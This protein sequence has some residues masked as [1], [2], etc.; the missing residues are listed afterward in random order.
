MSS[1]STT[2]PSQ[3]VEPVIHVDGSRVE[4]WESCPRKRYWRYEHAGTGITKSGEWLDPLIGTAVHNGIELLV[5]PHGIT[6]VSTL[7]NQAV[8][9]A[10]ETIAAARRAGPVSIY[11]GSF[12]ERN[13]VAELLPDRDF[14]QGSN[15]AEA[16]VRGWAAVRMPAY[17]ATHQVIAI[18]KECNVTFRSGGR[19]IQFMVR[20]DVVERRL[21][22]GALFARN[23]KTTSRVDQK[24]KDKWRH[25]LI[26]FSE[27]MAIESTLGERVEGLII[28]GLVKGSREDY[29]RE[30][31]PDNGP[32]LFNWNSPLVMAWK[33]DGE[34]P[35][36]EDQWFAKYVWRC[37]GPHEMGNRKKCPGGVE[38]R[39]SGVHKA[40][41]S[42]FPG[43][44]AGW[45]EMLRVEEPELLEQQFVEL[46]P[47]TRS[48]YEVERWQRQVLPRE[49]EIREHREML[50]QIE[51]P[52]HF[53]AMLDR[54]FPMST[55][56]GNCLW[57]SKCECYDIC[58]GTDMGDLAA[59]GWRP[60]S[61][62]HPQEGQGE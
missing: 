42:A 13:G 19:V 17:L 18:E 49:V 38:H 51:E 43:G 41:V 61:P 46:L 34:P 23:F 6:S 11:R 7:V 21:S 31:G 56:G 40:P 14:E 45:I 15:L 3:V 4:D 57:P 26:S 35:M 8:S 52:G 32:G 47:L 44:V 9:V 55:Q 60:R 27:S 54:W 16:L 59:A 25:G 53:E 39:L 62:N 1:S 20:P 24:W 10:R 12:R 5:S 29:E 58:W 22:D 30:T 36:T 2:A 28:E 50:R 37:T 48:Q 33:R